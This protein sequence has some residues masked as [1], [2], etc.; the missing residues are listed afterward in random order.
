MIQDEIFS[1]LKRSLIK[2]ESCEQFPYKDTFGNIGIGIGYNLSDRGLPMSWIDN[3]FKEDA[4]FFFDS[5]S[6]NYPFFCE[7][8][9]DRQIILVDMS[10]M[11]LKKIDEFTKMWEAIKNKDFSLASI[12]MLNSQW[13]EQVKGRA[14]DLAYAMKSGVYDV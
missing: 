11:G 14:V 6:K 7:L 13:A 1:K 12:E 5:L 2:H 10:F 3:Q 4:E 8:N 9:G